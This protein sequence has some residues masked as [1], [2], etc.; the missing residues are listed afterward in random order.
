[1]DSPRASL[2]GAAIGSGLT[3]AWEYFI[4]H[5]DARRR[6][7]NLF[8]ALKSDVFTNMATIRRILSFLEEENTILTT[9]SSLIGP[10]GTLN[11]SLWELLRLNLP[12]KIQNNKY[13]LSLTSISYYFI[14]D[15]NRLLA[16]REQYKL[17]NE[18]MSNYSHRLT[19]YNKSIIQDL[20]ATYATLEN[21]YKALSEEETNFVINVRNGVSRILLLCKARIIIFYRSVNVK[22]SEPW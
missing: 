15:S 9:N 2:I 1:M 21:L 7:I 13:T 5:K 22:L 8:D 19:I 18:G 3:I 10:I 4:R 16:T 11:A 6:D 14:Q 12:S 17:Y 20:N